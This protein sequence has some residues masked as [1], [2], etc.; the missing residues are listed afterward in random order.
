MS[1]E[2]GQGKRE[3]SKEKAFGGEGERDLLVREKRARGAR[4]ERLA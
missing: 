3:G 1:V 2:G 4:R